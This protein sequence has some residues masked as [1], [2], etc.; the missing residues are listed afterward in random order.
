MLK[1]AQRWP[2]WAQQRHGASG[3]FSAAEIAT[4][5]A[6]NGLAALWD[7]QVASSV[8]LNGADVSGL[9]DLSGA[10]NDLTQATAANQPLYT[11]APSYNGWPS[12]QYTA[13]NVDTLFRA[14]TNLK[15]TLPC[16]IV[17]VQRLS[18][19][20]AGAKGILCNEPASTGLGVALG[21]NG[22]D[23]AR[24]WHDAAAAFR[25]DGV[26]SLIAPEVWV[27]RVIHASTTPIL[28]VNGTNQPLTNG[29]I[30]PTD[31]GASAALTIGAFFSGNASANNMDHLLGAWFQSF[32][33]DALALS[34]TQRLMTRLG[35]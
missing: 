3:P 11:G 14:N 34:L 21:R 23:N 31:P 8:I 10:G 30:T 9:L 24:S 1:G 13:A 32:I 6:V 16:T 17:S 4:M 35:I 28:W 33:P 12:I 20:T 27:G 5:V 7:T 26:A 2:G 29:L 25:S 15:S 19:G 18:A 22:S